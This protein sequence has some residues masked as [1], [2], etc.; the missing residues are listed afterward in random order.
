VKKAPPRKSAVN[1]NDAI[2]EVMALTESELQRN[3]VKLQRRLSS[4]LPLVTADRIQPQQV[5]LN[6]I[7][8]AIEAMSGP[9]D[10]PRELTVVT[11]GSEPG[12]VFVEVRDSGPGLDPASLDHVFDTL[13]TTKPNGTG[14][15][16]AICRAIV[17]VHGGR[18]SAA[19]PQGASFRFTLPL[20]DESS[21]GPAPSHC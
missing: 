6:L 21:P 17:E 16:L 15:G 10:G 13:Y 3:R 12:D 14:M 18:I 8:N 11:G 19:E 1:I 2:V 4:A 9:A 20:A 7:V 5:I